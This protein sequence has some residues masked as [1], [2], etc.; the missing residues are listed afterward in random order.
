MLLR[1][2]KAIE[3]SVGRV[4][5]IRNGPRAVDLDVILYDDAIIDTRAANKRAD[6]ENLTGELVVPHP[7]MTEREF[8]LRPLYEYATLSKFLYK[9]NFDSSLQHDSGLHSPRI[10]QVNSFTSPFHTTRSRLP[11]EKGHPLPPTS[12]PFTILACVYR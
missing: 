8:V 2:L 4:P 10:P 1:L 11:Y 6:L 12:Y 3:E 9:G 7:R 5:S